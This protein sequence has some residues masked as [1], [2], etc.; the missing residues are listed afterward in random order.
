MHVPLYL[1][2]VMGILVV[3]DDLKHRTINNSVAF[4]IVREQI[5]LSKVIVGIAASALCLLVTESVLM[6]SGYLLLEDSGAAYT[7]SLLKGTAACIPAWTAG[8]IAIISLCYLTGSGGASIWGWLLIM[9]VAPTMVGILGMKFQFCA[10]LSSWLLYPLISTTIQTEEWLEYSW[11]TTAGFLKC[12]AA[13]VIGMG[14]FT[15]LGI[16]A[17]RRREL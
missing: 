16:L 15:T 14:V 2:S 7:L 8:L 5:F 12:Q 3:C 9:V 11:S 10:R 6:G 4:G 13:G 1:S 17:I